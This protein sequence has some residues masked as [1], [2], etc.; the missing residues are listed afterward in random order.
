MIHLMIMMLE[1]VGI[2]VILGFILAHTKLFRQALQNQ[3]GYKGKA[4][5]ISI[6]SQQLYRHRNSKEYDCKQ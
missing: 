6:F 3:D 1:R 2:I 5:L 4:I